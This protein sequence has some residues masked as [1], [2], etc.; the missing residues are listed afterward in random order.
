MLNG[1]T[2]P[3]Q[4]NELKVKDFSMTVIK[5]EKAQEKICSPYRTLLTCLSISEQ[6]FFFKIQRFGEPSLECIMITP[7][8]MLFPK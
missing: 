8:D 4:R 2:L 5:G 7:N 3:I 1:L 6:L